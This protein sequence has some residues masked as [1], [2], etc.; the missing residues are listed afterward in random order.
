MYAINLAYHRFFSWTIYE[1]MVE[2]DSKY[3]L[4]GQEETQA[5]AQCVR[6]HLSVTIISSKGCYGILLWYEHAAPS[7]ACAGNLIP[8]AIVLGGGTEWEDYR[9]CVLH[10]HE[11]TNAN[12]K[13]A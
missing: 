13:S 12:H 10:P 3:R 2:V 8:N 4:I 9:S 5:L 7:K 6:T 11:W 1:H